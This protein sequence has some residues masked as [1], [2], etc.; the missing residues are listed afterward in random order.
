MFSL[1]HSIAKNSMRSA[2]AINPVRSADTFRYKLKPLCAT[3]DQHLALSAKRNG[4][5]RRTIVCPLCEHCTKYI[6]PYNAPCTCQA[7]VTS[8]STKI[9]HIA[10]AI[11]EL[12]LSEGISQS[13]NQSVSQS[14][15]RKF[16]CLKK[17]FLCNLLE[18]F[19]V[20]LW[21][22]QYSFTLEIE[23]QH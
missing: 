22:N 15:S 9:K 3:V 2:S 11:I 5:Q 12:H 13:V 8:S 21:A 16:H 10:L 18:A 1:L 17:K 14:S 20:A 4:P 19:Q 6:V 7:E 23:R